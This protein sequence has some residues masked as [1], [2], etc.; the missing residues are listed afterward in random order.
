MLNIHIKC[1]ASVGSNFAINC[2]EATRGQQDDVD[3]QITHDDAVEIVCRPT[4]YYPG[5][6]YIFNDD[7]DDTVSATMSTA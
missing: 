1:A 3:L 4:L 2:S 5:D 6:K 7:C